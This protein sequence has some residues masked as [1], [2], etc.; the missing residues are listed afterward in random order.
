MTPQLQQAI[1]LLQLS[2]LDLQ[3][4]I[5]EALESNPMLERQEEGEDFD[6]SD[7]LADNIEQKPASD[8]QEPSYQQESATTVDNLEEGEWNDRIPNELPVDTAWEDV[9]QT[10]ASSLPSN[11]DD[12]WDF[13][14]RTSAGES[15]QSHLLWQLNLAPMSDTDRLIGVT[16]ID[17]INTQGYLDETLEEILEAFDPELDIELDEIEAVLHRIQQFEPAGIGARNLGECLLLQLRQLPATT[18][19]LEDAKRLVTDYIDLLGAR[20][21]SQLMRRMKLK[22]DEL[23]QVIEL[24]K[25]L[26]R[27]RDR[28]LSPQNR[29]TLY[30]T[31]SCA[32]TTNAGS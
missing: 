5:Q 32:K 23:R 14:T 15:L 3:Q 10:S 13:T 21:Y 24:C 30:P 25:A 17:C 12:E 9:Y 2:T 20:D 31:S 8:I 18:P 11:D 6:N 27:V 22:E 1:R 7:P 26:I 4:E 19:W 16:L 28:K 29:N